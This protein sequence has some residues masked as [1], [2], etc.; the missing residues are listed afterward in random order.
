MTSD[1]LLILGAKGDPAEKGGYSEAQKQLMQSRLFSLLIKRCNRYTM[2][3]SSS[4]PVETA[5]AL[6]SSILFT[7][8]QYIREHGDSALLLQEDW[9]DILSLGNRELQT[10][11]ARAKREL[12]R[13]KVCA[14]AVQSLAYSDTLKA[15]GDFFSH[16]DSA[17]FA[18][19]IPCDID[20]PLCNPPDERLQGIE[21]IETYIH[22]L[23]LENTFCSRFP[24][25][26]IR[27]LTDCVPEYHE[28]LLNTYASVGAYALCR[29]L[30]ELPPCPLVLSKIA[31]QALASAVCAMRVSECETALQNAAAQLCERI[32]P[33]E[34]EQKDYLSRY[35]RAFAPQLYEAAAH[36]TIDGLLMS[37]N[38]WK[39]D[40]TIKYKPAFKHPI[41]GG[42]RK[43]R[44]KQLLR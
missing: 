21:Y 8:R 40:V 22:T 32:F 31:Q 39:S 15:L 44:I 5:E 33:G 37:E 1:E 14:P 36:D 34:W 18:Q 11:C 12:T 30:L 35:A 29:A 24:A 26:Q 42:V 28:L 3:D 41:T 23:V 10:R 25:Q 43:N 7:L 16:Y 20:Y 19:D 17:F 27:D 6:L 13:M 4:L 38:I 2:G 9:D